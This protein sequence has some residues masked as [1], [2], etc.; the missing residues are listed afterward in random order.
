MSS[1]MAEFAQK[2]IPKMVKAPIFFL[3][4]DHKKLEDC[5]LQFLNILFSSRVNKVLKI[6]KS[7]QN[8]RTGNM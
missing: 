8:V 3:T 4:R 5:R 7:R 1:V 6:L 2:L